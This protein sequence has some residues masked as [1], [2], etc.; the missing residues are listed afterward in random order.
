MVPRTTDRPEE[1]GVL[2][3][4]KTGTIAIKSAVAVPEV[5]GV[6]TTTVVVEGHTLPTTPLD[7]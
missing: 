7:P 3:P 6:A 2:M 4:V 5:G 1:A